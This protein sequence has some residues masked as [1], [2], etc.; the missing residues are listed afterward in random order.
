MAA[1]DKMFVSLFDTSV[2]EAYS[3][4]TAYDIS[5]AGSADSSKDVSSQTGNP[6]GVVLDPTGTTMYVA[7][8]GEGKVFQYN[9]STPWDLSTASL[10]T[11]LSAG[12][13][14]T[15]GISFKPDGTQAF[16]MDNSNNRIRSYN[17]STAW[18]LGTA[19][20]GSST[21]SGIA[22]NSTG[23]FIGK[24]GTKMYVADN[25]NDTIDEFDLSTPWDVSTNSLNQ[26]R[27]VSS[28]VSNLRDVAFSEDGTKMFITGSNYN[29]VHEFDLSIAWDVSTESLTD[30][31]GVSDGPSGVSFQLS[32]I[33][34]SFTPRVT[35][36]M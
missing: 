12:G 28:Q 34:S 29:E 2:V 19:T 25:S 27:D 24:D 9:L 17:L 31:K 11:S 6:A 33:A 8:Y 4:T 13:S 22:S 30:T 18:D 26:S 23:V 32:E 35:S 21:T 16:V 14:F 15:A 36:I 1:G 5:T 20:A 3:L 10:D 7:G